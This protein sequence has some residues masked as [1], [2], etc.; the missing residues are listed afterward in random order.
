MRYLSWWCFLPET[1]HFKGRDA[2][3]CLGSTC[4][5]ESENVRVNTRLEA[6]K[7]FPILRGALIRMG[8]RHTKGRSGEVAGLVV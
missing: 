7:S 3:H 8:P 5:E 1:L 4:W 2:D 6:H